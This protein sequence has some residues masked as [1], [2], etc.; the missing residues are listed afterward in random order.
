MVGAAVVVEE[1]EE[2]GHEEEVAEEASLGARRNV[3]IEQAVD[4]VAIT[5]DLPKVDI[6]MR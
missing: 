2:E 4:E 5:R 6:V 3:G 1:A